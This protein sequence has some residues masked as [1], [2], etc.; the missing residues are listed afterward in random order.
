M[1]GFS[2]QRGHNFLEILLELR[3]H[4]VAVHLLP[5]L[6][7][8]GFIYLI[9]VDAKEECRAN[10]LRDSGNAD[11]AVFILLDNGMRLLATSAAVFDVDF[12]HAL[13]LPC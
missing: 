10:L 3:K 4:R 1:H 9:L 6:E 5:L 2:P 7:H 11:L 8:S 13:V 12:Y